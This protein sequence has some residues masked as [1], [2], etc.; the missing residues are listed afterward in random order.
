MKGMEGGVAGDRWVIQF[1]ADY[2]DTH[3]S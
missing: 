1:N 3:P 2:I